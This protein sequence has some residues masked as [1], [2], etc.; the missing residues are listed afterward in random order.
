ML[1]P[2]YADKVE[3]LV[4]AARG[5]ERKGRAFSMREEGARLA[6]V[7]AF[8]RTWPQLVQNRLREFANQYQD[9]RSQANKDLGI[10]L[11]GAAQ[12]S[13]EEANAQLA[14]LRSEVERFRTDAKLLGVPPGVVHKEFKDSALP[15]VIRPIEPDPQ[16]RNRVRTVGS[17]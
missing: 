2:G 17:R 6:G 4:Y 11:P 7:R 5:A 9:I 14:K 13:I 8:S 15:T 12:R 1:D 16:Q 3:R 10:N